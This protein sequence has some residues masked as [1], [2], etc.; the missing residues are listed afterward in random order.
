MTPF[1]QMALEIAEE[2]GYNAIWGL[3]TSCLEYM[4]EDDVEDMLKMNEYL[5]PPEME[6]WDDDSALEAYSLECAFGPEE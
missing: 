1:K 6:D 2:G 3:L 5:N 4:S